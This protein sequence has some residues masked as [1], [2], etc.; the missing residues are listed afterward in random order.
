MRSSFSDNIQEILA[1]VGLLSHL[2]MNEITRIH[3]FICVQLHCNFSMFTGSLLF[4]TE[5]KHT[6]EGQKSGK[7]K[8][9]AREKRW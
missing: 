5:G 6:M 9:V 2:A 7:E 1:G 3:I 4:P 8:Y